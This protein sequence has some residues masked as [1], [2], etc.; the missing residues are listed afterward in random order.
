MTHLSLVE[1]TVVQSAG[2]VV[3][4]MSGEKVM[5]SINSGKYY[6]LGAVGGRVWELMASPIPVKRLV[7]ELVAEYDIDRSACE[8]Q[9]T[10]F[11]KN[12]HGEA[13]IEVRKGEG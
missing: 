7:D 1:Q 2:S 3:S 10:A 8:E 4:D 13:L 6:N 12:L 9:V 11:L 5:F